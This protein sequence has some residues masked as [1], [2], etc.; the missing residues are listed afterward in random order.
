MPAKLFQL[1]SA[2]SLPFQGV[3]F[4]PCSCASSLPCLVVASIAT[5]EEQLL[6]PLQFN[7]GATV[8]TFCVSMVT[9]T[10]NVNGQRHAGG[11]ADALT[12]VRAVVQCADN[13]ECTTTGDFDD[14]LAVGVIDTLSFCWSA[15]ERCS[16]FRRKSRS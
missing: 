7:V 15:S 3:S 4:T 16:A 12:R 13:I 10:L 14:G 9:C 11:T 5:A 6:R 1:C 8:P 2:V